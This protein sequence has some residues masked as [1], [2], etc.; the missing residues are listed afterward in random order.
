[1]EMQGR[2]IQVKTSFVP[3]LSQIQDCGLYS[4]MPYIGFLFI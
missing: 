2:L 3:H 1:M 4:H